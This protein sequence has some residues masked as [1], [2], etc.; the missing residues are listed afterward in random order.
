MPLNVFSGVGELTWKKT[1]APLTSLT[2]CH[3]T[4]MLETAKAGIAHR[5]TTKPIF[6]MRENMTSS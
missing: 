2:G 6:L 3:R 5:K 4:V 1:G